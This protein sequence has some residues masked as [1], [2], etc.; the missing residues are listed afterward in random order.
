MLALLFPKAQLIAHAG[1]AAVRMHLLIAMSAYGLITVAAFQALL[2]SA[3]DRRLHFP[4]ASVSAATKSLWSE[5]GRLLDAQPPLLAQ[6]QLLFRVIWVAFGAL[7]LAVASGSLISVAASGKLLPFDHKTVFTLLSWITFGVLLIGR[8]LSG[9]RGRIALRY[10]LA[11]FAFIVL[12]Y[13]GSRFVIE[14]ILRRA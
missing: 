14:V 11:G 3:L 6:E 9:W 1:D 2:M 4:R 8:H 13:T 5:A 10:T 12:S 7:T